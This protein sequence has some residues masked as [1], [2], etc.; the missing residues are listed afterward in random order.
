VVGIDREFLLPDTPTMRASKDTH[1]NPYGHK[2]L[3]LCKA[4]GMRIVNGRL[5]EDTDGSYTYCNIHGTSVIDYLLSRECD[6]SLVKHFNVCDFNE[7]SDHAPLQF[8]LDIGNH[9][10]TV[11]SYNYISYKWN[12]LNRDIF[13]SKIIGRLPDFNRLTNNLNTLD[14]NTINEVVD[15]F[16]LIIRECAEPLFSK[17]C[18]ENK[19]GFTDNVFSSKQWFDTECRVAKGVYKDALRQFNNERTDRNRVVLCEHKKSYKSIVRKKRRQYM[20]KKRDEILN[21]RHSNP[22]QF[23]RYFKRKKSTNDLSIG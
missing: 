17:S 5:C 1:I 11:T 6:F 13:R 21:L 16:S 14:R 20:V 2:L 23:W 19:I 15:N 9:T 3:S 10:E 12:P 22:R 4:T 18:R 7:W 8:V